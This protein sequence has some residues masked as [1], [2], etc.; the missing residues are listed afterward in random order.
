MSKLGIKILKIVTLISFVSM[1]LMITS[2]ILIFN[3]IFLT[4]QMKAKGEKYV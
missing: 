3:S 1:A 2:S 4:Q